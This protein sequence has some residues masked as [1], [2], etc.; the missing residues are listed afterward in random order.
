[1]AWKEA[2]MTDQRKQFINQY[3]EKKL[4]ISELCR[5]FEI[6]RKCGYK[7]IARFKKEGLDGL[8]DRSRAPTLQANITTVEVEDEILAIKF[9]YP[10]LGPKKVKAILDREKPNMHWPSKTT[11][12]KIFERN[13]LVIP[14]KYRKRLPERN[15]SLVDCHQCNDTWCIDFKGN[16]LTKDN[17]R[18]DPFTLMDAH[19]RYLLACVQLNQNDFKHVWGIFDLYFREYGLPL[20]VRSDNGPPFATNSPG[21]LSR[22]S[23]NLIKAGVM[24]EWID[25]GEP[26]Q[27]GRHERMHLT[28]K[29]ESIFPDQ[30]TLSEQKKQF[31]EFK[32][33]YNYIRPHEA[34]NQ[35]TPGDVYVSSSRL[36]SGRLK[37]PEYSDEYRIG[38]VKSCG[39]MSWQGSEI[40]I[41]RVLEGEPIGLKKNEKDV[42]TAYYGPIFLGEI[43]NKEL[44]IQRRK[45]RTR[46]NHLK[47]KK[48]YE[49]AL[50]G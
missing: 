47:M 50:A 8:L 35:K 10:K 38:K 49:N 48:L 22:L 44:K 16:F 6:S 24:P 14:R 34:L 19:S 39:K 3:L 30:L 33:Y 42:L 11:I 1:M 2:K 46:I 13:G 43:E 32:D 45:M 20:R 37:S 25:P 15:S 26:Q 40:Y 21:R 12:G 36:W 31:D 17:L 28:L 4:S 7:W 5:Q 9:L 18:C 23:I 41:G 27:N 29:Q